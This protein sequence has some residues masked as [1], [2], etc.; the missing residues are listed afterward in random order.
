MK[1]TAFTTG[2]LVG[3]IFLTMVFWVLWC[4]MVFSGASRC[5]GCSGVCLSAGGFVCRCE[6][7]LGMGLSWCVFV[8]VWV[9]RRVGLS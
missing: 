8:L 4:A 9:C 1:K 3:V 2:C 7:L 6:G 5:S